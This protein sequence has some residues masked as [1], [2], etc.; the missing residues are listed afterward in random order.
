M[1]E[2][3]KFGKAIWE[4]TGKGNDVDI[5]FEHPGEATFP[6]SV[7]V[8]K[9]GGMVVICAGTTRLQPHPGRALPVDAPEAHAGQPLRQ[10]QA[11]QRRP[12]SWWSTRQVDPCMSEVFAW[13]DIP[14]AHD[15]MRK[16]QH[17]PGNMAV[18]VQAQAAGHAHARGCDRGLSTAAHSPASGARCAMACRSRA[19]RQR[20]AAAAGDRRRAAAPRPSCWRAP[21]EAVRAPVAPT[22]QRSSRALLEREQHA[23]HGLAWLA[24]YVEA[25]RQMQGWAQ[26][27]DEAGRLGEL[28]RLMLRDRRS[29][30][31]SPASPAA[32]R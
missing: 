10:P 15:K 27:L 31:T 6:V 29:A 17:K 24:T 18:L 22:G 12:T 5:V 26:R 25:L 4:I 32:S 8:V 2:A 28:E 9:R 1:K 19:C 20:R 30:N 14:R 11:G 13:H 23:A 21:R 16:N 3:R 7:F